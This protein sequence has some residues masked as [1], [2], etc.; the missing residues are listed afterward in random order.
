MGI[1]SRREER[2][3]REI[4][5]KK[6]GGRCNGRCEDYG[7]GLGIALPVTMMHSDH[8]DHD[9][10]D[11]IEN[12]QNLCPTCNLIKR[13]RGMAFLLE[14]NRKKWEK[15]Q[16]AL[17]FKRQPI[18]VRKQQPQPKPRRLLMLPLLPLPLL[19]DRG[20]ASANSPFYF[21]YRRSSLICET[22]SWLRWPFLTEGT[23]SEKKSSLLFC[24]FLSAK[25]SIRFLFSD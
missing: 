1:L 7:R 21:I 18:V 17:S 22:S 9:G 3:I 20:R 16:L 12:R 19:S 13:D 2:K 4:H 6:Q 14:N 24:K 23:R 5:H 8:I 11:G 15:T 25:E 10:P